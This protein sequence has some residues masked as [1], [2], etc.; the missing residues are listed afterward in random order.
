MFTYLSTVRY[1]RPRRQLQRR[2]HR[3]DIH[4]GCWLHLDLRLP[5]KSCLKTTVAGTS[6][7]LIF[8]ILDIGILASVYS[9]GGG[10][11]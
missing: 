8:E 11:A 3:A 4:E 2:A 9:S 5:V 7:A 1:Q 10:G 6:L